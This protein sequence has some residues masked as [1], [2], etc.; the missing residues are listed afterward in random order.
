V[1]GDGGWL[2]PPYPGQQ[3][4]SACKGYSAASQ[5]TWGDISHLQEQDTSEPN[6]FAHEVATFTELL[7]RH[8]VVGRDGLLSIAI[9]K[10]HSPPDKLQ[11]KLDGETNR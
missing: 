8:V 6:V 10:V 1:T 9:H 7:C 11:C 4:W 2:P 3:Q 5:T